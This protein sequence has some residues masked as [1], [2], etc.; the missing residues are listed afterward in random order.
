M[1]GLD[2]IELI[3]WWDAVDAVDASNL[4]YALKLAQDVNHPDAEWLVSLFPNGVSELMDE[5]G[6]FEAQGDDPRALFFFYLMMGD[7]DAL[8]HSAFLGYAPAQAE[9]SM[10]VVGQAEKR[11]WLEK[12]LAQ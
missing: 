2:R 12:A 5:L 7:V 10:Y 11:A 8:E 9:W 4:G 3:R 6:V 1:S